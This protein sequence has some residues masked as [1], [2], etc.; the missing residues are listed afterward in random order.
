[1]VRLAC[2]AALV[3]AACAAE[4]AVPSRWPA[5][6]SPAVAQAD[7]YVTVAGVAVP[8]E[9]GTAYRAIFDAT[10]GGADPTALVP[11]VNMA[12]SELNALAASHVPLANAKFAI[13]FHGSAVDGLLDDAHYEAKFRVENPNLPAIAALKKAGVELFVCAQQLAA[14]NVDRSALTPDVT[15]ASDA[16]IVLMAYHDKGYAIL[17]Y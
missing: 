12:G 7:G 8:P 5:P 15:V 14:D 16:L 9:P 2:F 10:R 13:V 17:S 4:P 6:A 11:A 1:M 3:C